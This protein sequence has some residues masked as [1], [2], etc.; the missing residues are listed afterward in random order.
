MTTRPLHQGNQRR[1]PVNRFAALVAALFILG[2]GASA[3]EM[4]I[5]KADGT[6]IHESASRKAAKIGVVD[7]MG[8]VEVLERGK[9]WVKVKDPAFGVE[10]WVRRSAIHL[11]GD[12]LSSLSEPREARTCKLAPPVTLKV[13]C[14]RPVHA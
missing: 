10:G 13:P 11:A 9:D 4:G 6:A 7:R 12:P 8:P 2:A 1:R 14:R 3:A 5:V